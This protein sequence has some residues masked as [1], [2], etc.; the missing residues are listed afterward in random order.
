MI[1]LEDKSN[2]MYII[3]ENRYYYIINTTIDDTDTPKR[4]YFEN[5]RIK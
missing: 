4:N 3:I 2:E 1:T 5:V